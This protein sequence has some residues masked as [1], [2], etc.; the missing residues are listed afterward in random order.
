M[1]YGRDNQKEIRVS[2][3]N[4]RMISFPFGINNIFIPCYS[5]IRIFFKSMYV[6]IQSELVQLDFVYDLLCFLECFKF[7]YNSIDARFQNDLMAHK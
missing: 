2:I 3:Q 1:L 6:W 4:V 7:L 5:L